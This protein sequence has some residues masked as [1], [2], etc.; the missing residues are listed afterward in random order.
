MKELYCELQKLLYDVGFSVSPHHKT[1]SV[2]ALKARGILQRVS[3]LFLGPG[4][5]LKLQSSAIK[6]YT[7]N[8][9]RI[10]IP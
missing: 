5:T 10:P 6:E 4:V 9:N 3:G 7:L 1:Q 8:Y 2:E